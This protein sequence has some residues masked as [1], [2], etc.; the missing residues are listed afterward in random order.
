VNLPAR[1]RR[2]S[3]VVVKTMKKEDVLYRA[4]IDQFDIGKI[5]EISGKATSSALKT[6]IVEVKKGKKAG[7][8]K[9]PEGKIGKIDQHLFLR[10]KDGDTHIDDFLIAK[11]FTGAAVAVD[12]GGAYK[13]KVAAYIKARTDGYNQ[14]VAGEKQVKRLYGQL[15]T[16]LDQV[17]DTAEEAK[18]GGFGMTDP[19]GRAEKKVR[20]AIVLFTT[21]EKAFDDECHG[22]FSLHRDYKRPDDVDEEYVSEYTRTY[23]LT[24]WRPVYGKAKEYVEL[25][26]TAVAEIRAA[27]KN[28][29]NFADRA[30]HADAN[31]VSMAEELAALA[32]GEVTAATK[33]WGLQP[34]EGVAQAVTDDGGK[35]VGLRTNTNVSDRDRDSMTERYL[36]TAS[37]RMVAMKNGYSRLKKHIE[38]MDSQVKQLKDIP[39]P[40]L[41]LDAVK[42]AVRRV[43]AADK[44]LA[45]YVKTVEGHIKEAGKAFAT[46][47]KEAATV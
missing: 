11:N 10:L 25:S 4:P 5:S 34:V 19:G 41:K 18:R 33:V 40:Q 35:I 13:G 6:A 23:Y 31:W 21:I 8:Y 39:K 46:V 29:R 37:E 9:K 7:T 12:K 42:T 45:R 2:G 43:D 28:A 47:K 14:L 44:A 16:M 1:N 36:Q 32:E 27:A 3:H 15:M 26:K 22:P 24:Q 17:K 38:K 20:D 30:Q